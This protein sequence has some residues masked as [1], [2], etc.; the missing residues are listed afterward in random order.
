MTNN[1][2][3]HRP[4]SKRKGVLS[5]LFNQIIPPIMKKESTD[6]VALNINLIEMSSY[7][8]VIKTGFD[9]KGP[10]ANIER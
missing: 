6:S 1:D 10:N 4:K 5:W 7:I 9:T 8:P 2:P 3:Y